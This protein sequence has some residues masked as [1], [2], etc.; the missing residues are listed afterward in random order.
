MVRGIKLF[1]I[2]A[3]SVLFI[4]GCGNQKTLTCSMSEEDDG[5]SMN[6]ELNVVYEEDKIAN[7]R[8]SIDAKITDDQYQE[9][10]DMFVSMM[11]S[12]YEEKNGR[13]FTF[14]VPGLLTHTITATPSS[15]NP[16]S[17]SHLTITPITYNKDTNGTITL[18]LPKGLTIKPGSIKA[19][20]N[21][22][23]DN[24]N[25]VTLQDKDTNQ[26]HPDYEITSS[27]NSK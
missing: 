5:L 3:I 25:E 17:E 20:L 16:D 23:E 7:V 4:T 1:G 6:Q 27:S 9:Y 19:G 12:Q 18:T 10:W 2:L 24:D 13:A 11:E 21:T 26:N 14:L 22:K 15:L 8:M